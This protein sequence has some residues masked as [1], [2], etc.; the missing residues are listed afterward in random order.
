MIIDKLLGISPKVNSILSGAPETIKNQCTVEKFS[1]ES[2][3][4]RKDYGITSFFII[5]QGEVRVVNEFECGNLYVI[6]ENKAIDFIGDVAALAGLKKASATTQAIT[7][8]L[9]IKLPLS[10][11]YEWIKVD[12]SFLLMVSQ[13]VATKLYN[14]SYTK[15]MEL[16]Y[17]ATHLILN[18]IITYINTMKNPKRN[19]SSIYVKLTRQQIAETL[20]VTVRTVNRA[21]KRLKDDNLIFTSRGQIQINNNQ[22]RQLI[23]A[24]ETNKY[25]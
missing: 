17:P 16:Y 15:G 25:C 7:D 19:K 22:Y 5:C 4:Q 23:E 21:I 3:I 18:L 6:E 1:A 24:F 11:F 12:N 20:G 9:T 8:C 2:I 10:S 13:R 14:S